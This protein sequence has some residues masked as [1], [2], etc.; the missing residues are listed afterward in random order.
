MVGIGLY[1]AKSGESCEGGFD[2]LY[3]GAETLTCAF[4]RCERANFDVRQQRKKA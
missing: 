2:A 4:F 3:E 1:R